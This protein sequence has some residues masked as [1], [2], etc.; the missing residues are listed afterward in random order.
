M[1]FD[2][3]LYLPVIC[4][5]A[6]MTWLS[7]ISGLEV[8]Q[9]KVKFPSLLKQFVGSQPDQLSDVAVVCFGRR[10]RYS[11]LIS[12]PDALFPQK[13]KKKCCLRDFILHNFLTLIPSYLPNSVNCVSIIS[14]AKLTLFSAFLALGFLWH[15]LKVLYCLRKKV[16]I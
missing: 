1:I 7:K 15:Y 6:E 13:K 9:L 11:L 3:S 12:S 4:T 16:K 10:T 8:F 14:L 2:C 5:N